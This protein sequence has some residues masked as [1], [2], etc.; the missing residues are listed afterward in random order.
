MEDLVFIDENGNPIDFS[1]YANNAPKGPT[2]PEDIKV[3][4]SDSW[5]GNIAK[6]VADEARNPKQLA[7]SLGYSALD[8][9]THPSET[10]FDLALMGSLAGFGKGFALPVGLSFAGVN[11]MLRKG[12]ENVAKFIKH[13]AKHP[14]DLGHLV[15][16]A[17]MDW[18]DSETP[19][20]E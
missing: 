18:F 20:G 6:N 4:K 17:A 15:K 19:R 3:E 13:I 9:M 16:G 14:E 7:K 12:D 10:I 8:M 5:L 2:N 11:D 1:K